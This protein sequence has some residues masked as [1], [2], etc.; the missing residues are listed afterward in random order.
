VRLGVAI[1]GGPDG[2]SLAGAGLATIART[3]ERLGFDSLWFFDAIG[4]GFL[5]PDPL[6]GV[7]VAAAVTTRIE[8]GTCILQVPL[9]NPVELAHRILTAHQIAGGRLL[10]GVGAG[11]TPGDFEALGL[12]FAGRLQAFEAAL[13]VMRRLWRGE[14]VGRAHLAPWPAAQ[15][16]PAVLIG[17]WAGSRWIP[18]AAQEFDGW[19]GSAGKTTLRTLSEGIRRYRDAGGKRAIATTIVVDLEAPTEPCP[20]D[21]PFHLRCAPAAAAERLRRL[22]DL[23]FDDAVLVPRSNSEADLAAARALLS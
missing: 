23:G 9:R 2:A 16:G 18:R 10:L 13:P 12:D 20:D 5:L 17:S 6:I 11:S 8:I 4:R 19:I 3:A 14:K 1:T 7:S 22:A 21:G 15:G